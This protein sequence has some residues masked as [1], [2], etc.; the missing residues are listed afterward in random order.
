MR[1]KAIRLGGQGSRE[2]AIRQTLWNLVQNVLGCPDFKSNLY[3]SVLRPPGRLLDFGCAN[4]HLAEVFLEFDYCGIDIDSGAINAAKESFK[5]HPSAKFLAADIHSRPYEP[6][7]FDEILLAGTAHHLTNEL[8][9]SILGELHYCL[10]PGKAIHLIDPVLQ[11]KDGWQ[12]KFLRRLDRGRY[13]RNLNEFMV[14]IDSLKL[15]E[16]GEPTF[17]TPY[18]SPIQDCDF[19]YVPLRKQG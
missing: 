13:A 7:F 16:V 18:G 12:S 5:A 15:F 9:V 2:I 8:F 14:L 11:E 4:G 1:S 17:H 19:V 6:N 10:K 3:R